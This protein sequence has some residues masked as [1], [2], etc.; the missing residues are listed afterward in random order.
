MVALWSISKALQIPIDTK[1][2]ELKEVPYTISYIIRKRVQIDN[3]NE[4]GKDKRPPDKI[5]WEGSSEE[6][7]DWLDKVLQTNPKKKQVA[8]FIIND[9]EG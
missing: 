4:L 9:V 1:I 7:D 8:E 5:L 3:L 2:T 6:L